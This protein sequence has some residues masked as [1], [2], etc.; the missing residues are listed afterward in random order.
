MLAFFVSRIREGVL[1]SVNPQRIVI[2]QASP[3]SGRAILIILDYGKPS[4]K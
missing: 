3:V 2:V 4:D 1:D